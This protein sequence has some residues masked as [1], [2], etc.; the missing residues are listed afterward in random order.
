MPQPINWLKYADP[1]MLSQEA[2]ATQA[3]EKKGIGPY[4]YIALTAGNIADGYTTYKAMTERGAREM[5]PILPKN[6]AALMAVKA[7]SSIPEAL[8]VRS[9]SKN[10][11]KIAKAMGYSMGA[12]GG[13]LAL[14]NH[15]VGRK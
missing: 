15:N 7:L 14:H 4:P 3:E 10:H 2:P 8:I 6:P 9:L 12:L 1:A 13:L 5:N 11:P